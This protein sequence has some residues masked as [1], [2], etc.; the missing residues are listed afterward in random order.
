MASNMFL[1]KLKSYFLI[2]AGY[3]A[4]FKCCKMQ[5]LLITLFLDKLLLLSKVLRSYA[6]AEMFLNFV[7]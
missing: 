1:Q 7:V 6:K 3:I 2:E 5:R 4:L